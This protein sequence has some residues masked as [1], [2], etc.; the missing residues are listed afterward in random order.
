MPDPHA[1][2]A[3]LEAGD[4]FCEDTHD[5]VLAEFVAFLREERRYWIAPFA[6]CLLLLSTLLIAVQG[7]AIAP[8]VYTLW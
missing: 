2:G 7:S 1:T 6:L 4:P 8:F 5:S 3:G